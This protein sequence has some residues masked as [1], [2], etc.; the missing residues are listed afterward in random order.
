MKRILLKLSG[1]SLGGK[2][3]GIDKEKL[4]H[5]A[6][7]IKDAVE[8]GKEVGIIVGGGNF[9][10]GTMTHELGIERTKLDY[11][12]MLATIINSLALQDALRALNIPSVVMSAFPIEGLC[13]KFYFEKAIEYLENGYVVFIAAG[14]GNPYFTTD[15]AAALRAIEI[16]ANVLIKGTRVDGVY[17]KDPE[18]FADAIRFEQLSFEEVIKRKLR[19]MDITAFTLCQENHLPIVVLNIEERGNV[20]K[21]LLGEK[22]GTV[23]S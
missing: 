8:L 2:Q 21:F 12:G 20:K 16:K 19:V 18:K 1:E 10:R 17:D 23:V 13:E 14:T 5:F 15:S 4:S 3:Q 11:M 9:I 22:V 6:L 7:E